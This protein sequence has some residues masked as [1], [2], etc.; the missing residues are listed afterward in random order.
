[1]RFI[2]DRTDERGNFSVVGSLCIR[3]H[4]Y[5]YPRF[6]RV[7][8]PFGLGSKRSPQKVERF[9]K[10]A[11]LFW[12]SWRLV[13]LDELRELDFNRDVI[14]QLGAIQAVDDI[15]AMPDLSYFSLESRQVH[16]HEL[17]P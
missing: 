12:E 2:Q 14:N 8:S 9:G 3:D 7:S 15:G 1:L 6:P 17:L 5:N 11:H 16:F 10:L 13:E 4:N